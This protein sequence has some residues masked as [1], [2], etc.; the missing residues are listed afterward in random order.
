MATGKISYDRND[1][2]VQLLHRTL[3]SGNSFDFK[4]P[5]GQAIVLC[6]HPWMSS[7]GGRAAWYCL[8]YSEGDSNIVPLITAN[9]VT[10]TVLTGGKYR[11][12]ATKGTFCTVFNAVEA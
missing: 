2:D 9:G 1:R 5:Y 6:N 4:V 7:G 12:T 11:V 3:P 8:S 10:C